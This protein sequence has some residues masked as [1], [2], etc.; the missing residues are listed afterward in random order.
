MLH[1]RQGS[2]GAFR[3][4]DLPTELV[5][6]IFQFISAIDIFDE[7][8]FFESLSNLWQVGATCRVLAIEG[9]LQLIKHCLHIVA[10]VKHYILP[11]WLRRVIQRGCLWIKMRCGRTA[12]LPRS[13]VTV[14][15]KKIRE[16]VEKLGI[17]RFKAHKEYLIEHSIIGRERAKALYSLYITSYED[18][19]YRDYWFMRMETQVHLW[20]LLT[21]LLEIPDRDVPSGRTPFGELRN[22]L[23]EGGVHFGFN[24]HSSHLRPSGDTVE[25]LNVLHLTDWPSAI[26][27]KSM[28]RCINLRSLYLADN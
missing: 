8:R 12:S 4:F 6:C 1:D 25:D 13:F 21:F 17:Q 19:R 16:A 14:D 7:Y 23:C 11:S 18:L 15:I 9:F 2:T 5:Q 10:S 22:P 26:V 3:L 27:P 24:N 28:N 20:Y